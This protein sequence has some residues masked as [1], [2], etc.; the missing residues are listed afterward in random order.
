MEAKTAS[1]ELP[2]TPS[3]ADVHAAWLAAGANGDVGAMRELW[4][5]F[6]KWLDFNRVKEH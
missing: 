3:M 5:Q 6:P 2:S 1:T 4:N